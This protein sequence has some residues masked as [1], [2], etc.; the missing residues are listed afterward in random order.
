MTAQSNLDLAKASTVKAALSV[1]SLASGSM[2]SALWNIKDVQGFGGQPFASF[3]FEEGALIQL[4]R[5]GPVNEITLNDWPRP[6]AV[7][8]RTA[9]PSMRVDNDN[10]SCSSCQHCFIGVR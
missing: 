8:G 10:R 2:R 9:M 4:R 7:V 5:V 3:S 6:R 1:D